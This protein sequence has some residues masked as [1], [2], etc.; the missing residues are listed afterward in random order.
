LLLGIPWFDSRS[1]MKLIFFI[2]LFIISGTGFS[3]ISSPGLGKAN[4]ASWFAFGIRQVLHPTIKIQSFTYIG[5]GRTSNLTD[6]DPFRKPAIFVINQEFYHQFHKH[7]QYSGAI[8]YRRQ[9]EYD[10]S[11]IKLQE[12]PKIIQ[13]F[14]TYGRLSFITEKS[15]FKF[16]ATYRQEFRSFFND[17][18]RFAE[19]DFQF[20]SRFRTQFVFSLNKQKT[21]K[22]SLSA[23]AL[24]STFHN[25]ESGKWSSLDYKESRFCLYFA[26]DPVKFPVIFSFGYMNNLLGTGPG[27][28][29]V[30]YFTADV[31]WENPFGNLKKKKPK[32]VEYFE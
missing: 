16:V 26:I 27:L 11:N 1:E 15:P 24:F 8:S 14:R 4:T 31:I 7:W 9:N 23:E 30:H 13:E 20:R 29:D 25:S 19:E 17:H 22:L 21:L 6:A 3:Q 32:P 5:F 2:L 28:N 10:N 12:F 18:F